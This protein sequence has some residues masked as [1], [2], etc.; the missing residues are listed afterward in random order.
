M[1]PITTNLATLIAQREEKLQL[2]AELEAKLL[3]NQ[4]QKEKIA[5]E[6]SGVNDTPALSKLELLGAHREL[7]SNK[8]TLIGRELDG[9]KIQIAG[10][11]AWARQKAVELLAERREKIMDQFRKRLENFYP[12]TR[13]L[14]RILESLRAGGSRPPEVERLSTWIGAIS[15]QYAPDRCPVEFGRQILG[16]VNNAFAQCFPATE[17][18]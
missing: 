15:G 4:A 18:A 7:A 3:E 16:L 12:E 6:A 2:K 14:D 1:K 13:V 10:E 17:E 9:Y 5:A 11:A 8:L